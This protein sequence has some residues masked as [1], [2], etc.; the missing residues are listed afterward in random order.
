[1]AR[2]PIE[3][4]ETQFE[5]HFRPHLSTPKR[6]FECKIPLYKVFNYILYKLRTGV[7]WEFLP[8]DDNEDGQPEIS[9][10]A[11][12]YHFRKWSRDGSLQ[13]LFDASIMTIKGELHL[14]EKL[15]KNQFSSPFPDFGQVGRDW[16]VVLGGL[17]LAALAT[18]RATIMTR[19]PYDSDSSDGAY[20]CLFPDIEQQGTG[21]KRT[22]DLREVINGLRYMTKTGCQWRMIP[23]EFPRW[24]HIAYYFYK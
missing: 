6:G 24:Y 3:V 18:R 15:F 11:P 2:I 9:Y 8:I 4:T 23:H 17:A 10:Q 21:R 12:Y 5:Q 13:R 7:Q 1:M 19:M 22:V 20:A 14:S 16:L